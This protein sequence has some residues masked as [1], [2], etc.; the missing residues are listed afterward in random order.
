MALS[1]DDLIGRQKDALREKLAKRAEHKSKIDA[2]REVCLAE[3]RDPSDAEAAEVTAARAANVEIDRETGEI[4]ARI[5]EL[6]EEKRSDEAAAKL[7][8]EVGPSANRAGDAT[9]VTSEPRTYS[10]E[11][12]PKGVRFLSDVA[13]QF[14]RGDMGAT[15]R[16]SRHMTEERVERGEQL[17]RA[18]GTSAFSGL[19]VPQ[20]LVDEFAPMARAGR[21]FADAC[22]HH[23][24]P[25]SGMVVNIGALTTGTSVAEQANEGDAVSE[26]NADDTLISVP[27][28]TNSGQQ[29][30]SRQGVERG[31]GVD[32]TTIEDLFSA[33]HTSLDSALLNRATT[34]LSAVAT[35]IAY[36]D[37][38]P[39]AAELYPKL[40]QGPAAVE[41]AMLNQ[42]D[43]NDTIAVMHS[44]RWYWLQSQLSST[45][46]MFGQPGVAP[47][48]AG[49]NDGK[50][51]GSAFRGV[52]PAGT[53]VVV[54]NNIATNLGAGTNEDEIYF[55][56]RKE[57]HL[58]EDPSAPLL[59]KADQAKAANLQILLV[60]YGYY[61]FLATRRAH[62]QKIG[63]TGL[64]T[65]A[66]A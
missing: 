9:R 38:S 45:W 26:T 46:P 37:A 23:D 28:R 15:E 7:A 19:V 55:A 35:S 36:T 54:D 58:W 56:A 61:A 62:A 1:I 33:Y 12:D 4:E 44:R 52:L 29:T 8:R 65:P 30:I 57:L 3:R 10:R 64:V 20:Y 42:A 27:V 43:P 24:L 13:A 49:Q 41:A 2:V 40:L 59:I 11:V 63:G 6:E 53:P 32:D 47:Q 25:D 16:L 18:V 22:R 48:L 21:P 50:P 17:D 39:T 66:W 14:M 51:Y 60:V 34:G 31:V 5:A